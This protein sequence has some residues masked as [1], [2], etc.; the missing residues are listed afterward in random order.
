MTSIEFLRS[1]PKLSSLLG[2]WEKCVGENPDGAFIH[3]AQITATRVQKYT[4]ATFFKRAQR[5]ALAY[6][7]VLKL[8]PGD[9]I[10]VCV[11]DLSDFALIVHGALLTGCVVIPVNSKATPKEL[12][13]ILKAGAPKAFIFP[14]SQSAA[15][16]TLLSKAPSVKHWI[17]TGQNQDGAGASRTGE[18]SVIRRLEAVLLSVAGEEFKPPQVEGAPPSG[19]VFSPNGKFVSASNAL[20]LSQEQILKKAWLSAKVIEQCEPTGSLWMSESEFTPEGF[21]FHFFMSLFHPGAVLV[22]PGFDEREFWAQALADDIQLAVLNNSQ[23]EILERKGKPRGWRK[24]DP[25]SVLITDEVRLDEKVLKSFSERFFTPCGVAFF[26]SRLAEYVSLRRPGV[27]DLK[28]I[29]GESGEILPSFG[30]LLG[31]AKVEESALSG[32]RSDSRYTWG[33]LF[34]KSLFADDY[35]DAGIRAAIVDVDGRDEL[36]IVGRV[37]ELIV[38]KGKL[39]NLELVNTLVAQLKGVVYGRAVAFPHDQFGQDFSV[40]V[41]PHRL[42]QMNRY[43][44]ELFLAEHLSREE[45][46]SSITLE[47]QTGAEPPKTEQELRARVGM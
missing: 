28:S 25:F 31:N 9:K 36:Y 18:N 43:D 2:A 22:R 11:N 24:P 38:R 41:I 47:D 16:A 46:P 30:T 45:M 5:H 1:Q 33:K 34:L 20:F 4:Y 26:S 27:T 17:V 35:F 13:E 3:V 29:R 10:A 40:Y 6:Q 8:V 12:A 44:V 19:V 21:L 14:P 39:I 23:L 7:A 37:K 32:L 42:A 15:I